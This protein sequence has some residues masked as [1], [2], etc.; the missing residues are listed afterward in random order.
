MIKKADVHQAIDDGMIDA[1]KD[2]AKLEAIN[3]LTES[4]Q[5]AE[6]QFETGLRVLKDANDRAHAVVDKIFPE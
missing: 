2:R 4:A 5:T 1:I 3:E 6:D